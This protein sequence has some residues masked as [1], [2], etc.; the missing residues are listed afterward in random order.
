MS[1]TDFGHQKVSF[2]EKTEK[3]DQVFDKVSDYYDLMNDLMSC[4]LHRVWK[5]WFTAQ[6]DLKAANRVLDLA[7]GSGDITLALLKKQP[8]LKITLA[9]PSKKM[10][11]QAAVKCAYQGALGPRSIP[12]CTFKQLWAENMSDF[13]DGHFDVIVCSFGFRNMTHKDQALKEMFRVLKP[14]GTLHLLEFSHVQGLLKTPYEI[15]RDQ[16]LPVIGTLVGDKQSYAYL[17][18]SISVFWDQKTFTEHLKQ[19]GFEDIEH[20]MYSQ[21]ICIHTQAKKK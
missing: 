18:E 13:E 8:E 9:D 5:Q 6:I 11:N 16:F 14:G 12:Q 10:L 17:A 7:C 1:D 19:A 15:Y 3:V 2:E 4:G 21:G 20:Q